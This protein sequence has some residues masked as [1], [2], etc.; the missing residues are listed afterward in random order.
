MDAADPRTNSWFLVDHPLPMAA[1]TAIY[2]LI[3]AIG[4]RVMN[5]RE[6]FDLKIVMILYNFA[7]VIINLHICYEI[8]VSVVLLKFNWICD[9]L[10]Y[11][12]DNNSIRLASALWWFYF[13]KVIEFID[14]FI[15]ILR[16]KNNQLSFLHI[17][18]HAT[19]VPL[20]WIGIKWYA[21]GLSFFSALCN[22]LVHVVMYTYYFLSAF[23]EMFQ[24][25]L[26]WKKYL[27][28]FQ[29]LQFFVVLVHIT[30]AFN[31]GCDYDWRPQVALFFYLIS[32]ILLFT[33]FYKHAY[34]N[35]KKKT[36]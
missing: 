34:N 3:V 26:W 16:K 5:K 32:H 9:D 18:H 17:Y 22:S 2:L 1:L 6:A 15:F 27:T 25:Y 29:L 7:L 23:G 13:S 21:G 12:E 8:F 4:P 35:N 31:V 36:D 30:I 20:W 28:M 10:T 24:K 19:M 14:T 11:S 33:N